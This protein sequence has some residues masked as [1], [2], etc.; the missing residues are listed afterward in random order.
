MEEEPDNKQ[1]GLSRREFLTHTTGLAAAA[2]ASP[3]I[4]GKATAS[5]SASSVNS[6]S[7]VA[8]RPNIVFVFSDQERYFRKLPP[9]LSLPGHERLQKTGTTFHNHFCPA[10]M[11]TSSRSVLLTGLSTVDNGMFENT[12]VA[13]VSDL[14]TDIPTIGHMLRKEGYYT[15]YKGK[16]HLGQKFE[17]S[18]SAIGLTEEMEKYGFSDFYSPGDIIAHTLGG[19]EFDNLIAG[20]AIT[21]LRRNGQRINDEG[22]PW[23]LFVSLINPH[24]IMY[25]NTDVPG[26]KVQD[27][28]YLTMHAAPA[29]R[30]K[31]YEAMWDMPIPKSLTQPFDEAGRPGAHREF[32]KMWGHVLGRIP[33]EEERWR[34]FNNFYINSIRSVDLQ[35][36]SIL[37]EL[38][39]L[40]LTGST[41]FVYPSDHGEMAGSHGL[42]GKGP[43]AYHETTHLPMYIVHPD[44]KGGQDA[45]ALTGHIDIVP[46]LLSL[47]GVDATR[48][49]ELAGRELPG[50][51]F[52]SVISNP[53]A[54]KVDATRDG[55]LF[56][57]SGMITNDGDLFDFIGAARAE[58]KKPVF[59]ILKAGF[60]PNMKKRGTLRSVFDGRYK[61][62]RY[63]SPLEHHRPDSVSELF[64]WNDVELYD[65]EKDPDEMINLANNRAANHDLINTMNNNLNALIKMEIGVDD[66]RELPNIPLVDWTIDRIS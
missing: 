57:Y 27:T 45:R 49:A 60:K 54:A 24:D 22:K 37:D 30:N 36:K 42:R 44:V 13:Y 11:C 43:F 7:S 17:H 41:A 33:P 32:D 3:L 39:E 31:L 64:K 53:G 20:S 46:T 40:G 2:I 52:T 55:V 9:G 19:Y 15:A 35:L 28:G 38:D 14:S 48:A 61:L 21:W 29:P 26:Q 47:A 56:T 51:D 8:P 16:W 65:L 62:T 1:R 50:K 6:I 18:D 25:F 23:C 58:G 63:F 12:D 4:L 59:K 10:V 5:P 34:R 66:G